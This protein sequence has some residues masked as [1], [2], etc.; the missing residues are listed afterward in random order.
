[1]EVADPINSRERWDASLGPSGPECNNLRQLGETGLDGTKWYCQPEGQPDTVFSDCH[2]ISIGGNDNWD[3]ETS[4]VEDMKGCQTHTFDCTL[5]G[6]QPKQKPDR[7]DIHFY[8]YCINDHNH[9]DE[10]GREYLTYFDIIARAGLKGPPTLLKM[11]VEGFEFDIFSHMIQ[12]ANQQPEQ[13]SYWL[14]QQ[15]QVEIHW[16]TRM[17]GVAWMA[18]TRTSAELALL[19]GMMFTGGGYM[20]IFQNWDKGCPSCIEVLYFRFTC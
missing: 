15:M 11:D 2:V 16:A 5:Q 6:G 18:R 14:P 8:P 4:V 19:S 3:F 7:D 10:H 20:P 12:Q 13:Y 1:V 17:R 9:V